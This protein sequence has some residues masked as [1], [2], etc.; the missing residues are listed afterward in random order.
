MFEKG[1]H[2]SDLVGPNP[3]EALLTGAIEIVAGTPPDGGETP[4]PA[5]PAK[6]NPDPVEAVF[7]CTAARKKE[8][9]FN[10]DAAMAETVAR[11]N[12][13][14]PPG[15]VEWAMVNR[16]DL[17]AAVDKTVAL[18]DEAAADN[19]AVVF[20]LALGDY[21]AAWQAIFDAYRRE[22]ATQDAGGV[23]S[24]EDFSCH[25]NTGDGYKNGV[26]GLRT[27]RSLSG[28]NPAIS[29][30]E[31]KTGDGGKPLESSDKKEQGYT[32]H[33]DE[34][35]NLPTT[36]ERPL[37]GPNKGRSGGPVRG[38]GQTPPNDMFPKTEHQDGVSPDPVQALLF[39]EM[40]TT[41]E[42]DSHPP[43][44]QLPFE[45][46][47]APTAWQEWL[48]RVKIV[49]VE[50][51]DTWRSALAAAKAAGVCG[52][53]TE[54]T[55]L[56]PFVNEIRLLQLAVPVYPAGKKNLVAEDGKGP[57]SGGNAVA[58]VADLWRF[59]KEDRRE[60]LDGVV[61]LMA[62]PDVSFAGHNLKFD[63]KFLRS[64]LA[65]AEGK[66]RW[67]GKRLPC[68]RLFD[69]MLASQLV[70][71]GDFIPEAQFSKWREEHGVHIVK[72]GN[73]PTRYFDRHGHE[74]KFERDTQKKIRPIYPTHSVD[75]Q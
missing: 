21:E 24:G 47:A 49:V 30:R 37:V 1:F 53:D 29:G 61:G 34:S 22:A 55:G 12:A 52:F 60:M 7:A 11:L 33:N 75:C 32:R 46:E 26:G 64:A 48:E 27:D 36:G 38:D 14:A 6:R 66:P 65:A 17:T 73:G 25:A 67:P 23:E 72:E 10:F 59:G 71:A 45:L 74:G 51:L 9:P 15:V 43:A 50:D 8:E 68:E 62:D 56:D 3:A 40:G 44:S 2:F 57:E 19:D 69:T 70:T 31:E 41:G 35:S 28:G 54:T 20:N 63:L 58:Y 4:G 18:L 5:N 42:K 13:A 16:P 39:P